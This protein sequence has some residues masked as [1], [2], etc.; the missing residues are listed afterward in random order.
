MT[1]SPPCSARDWKS[2]S[3]A[4]RD[5]YQREFTH[6]SGCCRTAPQKKVAA[7]AARPATLSARTTGGRNRS[8]L[9]VHNIH[10]PR[11]YSSH[12]TTPHQHNTQHMRA[13]ELP[14]RHARPW[15]P[16]RRPPPTPIHHTIPHQ[17]TYHYPPPNPDPTPCHTVPHHTLHTT[18]HTLGH[19]SSHGMPAMTSTASAPPTPIA[20]MPRPPAF[21]VWESVPIISPPGNA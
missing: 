2:A 11:P 20:H 3:E 13:L 15:R 16:P 21:G 5:V 14:P 18:H 6:N 8:S 4:W 17:T 19:L 1:P 10:H 12:H 7:G 9:R